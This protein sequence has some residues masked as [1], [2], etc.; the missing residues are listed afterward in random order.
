MTNAQQDRP[1]SSFSPKLDNNEQ[2]TGISFP[3]PSPL[4]GCPEGCHSCLH[5]QWCANTGSKLSRFGYCLWVRI[6]YE[7]IT[8]GVSLQKLH[9]PWRHQ[10]LYSALPI[11]QGS[12]PSLFLITIALPQAEHPWRSSF[13][14]LNLTTSPLKTGI[15]IPVPEGGCVEKMR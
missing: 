7:V 13:T 15:L 12:A 11:C 3:S 9:S 5:P 4:P 1:F 10:E 6:I 14:S 8:S 2:H